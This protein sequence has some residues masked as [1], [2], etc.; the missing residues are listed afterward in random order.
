M[1]LITW[2]PGARVLLLICAIF[3]TKALQAQLPFYTDDPAVT[4]K[5]KWHFEFFDELDVLQHSQ[6]PNLRQNT[7]NYKLNYGLPTTWS[8]T[9]TLLTWP[10]FARSERKLP[11]VRVTLTW[12]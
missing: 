1:N 7:A 4:E 3:L 12:E 2:H 9:S 8:W 10:S 6:Y 5:G 11:P